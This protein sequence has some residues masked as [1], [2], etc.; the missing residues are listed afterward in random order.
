M[1]TGVDAVVVPERRRERV[2]VLEANE[3]PAGTA[4]IAAVGGQREHAEQGQ[5]PHGAEKGRLVDVAEERDLCCAVGVGEREAR[6]RGREA[7]LEVRQS[8]AELRCLRRAPRVQRPVD[9]L[10]DPRLERAGRVVGG[11]D[12]GC[13]RGDVSGHRPA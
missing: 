12:L 5:E 9:E 7:R 6:V 4:A 2:L 8:G 3:P 1:E 11:H 10:E 13:D